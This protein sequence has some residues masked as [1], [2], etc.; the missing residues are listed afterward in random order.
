MGK[1]K[2]D[3]LFLFGRCVVCLEN[4]PRLK[5]NLLPDYRMWDRVTYEMDDL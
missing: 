2:K 3:Q 5:E 4:C 1:E